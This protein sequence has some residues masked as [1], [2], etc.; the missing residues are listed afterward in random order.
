MSELVAFR[1]AWLTGRRGRQDN[2]AKLDKA[3]DEYPA[4]QFR[5]NHFTIHLQRQSGTGIAR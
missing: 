1:V 3:G 2:I 4:P 5:L